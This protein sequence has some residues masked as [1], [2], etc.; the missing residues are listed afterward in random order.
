MHD[1]RAFRR[2]VVAGPLHRTELFQPGIGDGGKSRRQRRDLVHDLGG[3]G[4]A[5]LKAHRLGKPDGDFPVGKSITRRHH[6][7]DALDAPLGIGEGAVLLQEGRSRQEDVGIVGGLVEEEVMHDH[8]F[9]RRQRRHHMLGVGVGLQ[10]VFALHVEAHERAFDRS[11]EHVG[12]AQARFR[13]ELDVPHRLELVAH[14]VAR[15]MPVAGE[16]MRERAHVAGALHVVLAAQRVHADA[17]TADIAGRHREVG[18]RNHC[19]RPLA[20]LGHAKA[21]IDRAITAGGEQPRGFAQHLRIDAGHDRGRFR[22]V[23]RQRHEGGPLLELAPVA[24]LAHEGFIDEAFGNDDVRQ[25]REHGNVGAGHQR[26]MQR[27]EVRG[28]HHLR[29]A[30]INHDELGALAQ[31][32]LQPRGEYGVGGGGIGADHHDDVGMLDGIEILRAGRGTERRRQA[33]AGRRMADAGAGVDIVVAESAADQLLHQIGFFIGAAG[34]GDAA[35]RIAAILLLYALEFRRGEAECLVP[36]DLAPGILDPLADHRFED[37]LLVCGI[38]PGEA[39]LDAGMAAIGLAVL[40]GHHAHDFLAAHFRLEGA[41]DAA[42]STRRHHGMFRLADLDHG[43]F[44]QRRGRAGLYAGAAGHAFGAEKILVHAGRNAA[45][46]TAAGNRQRK[47][48]LHLLAG[49]DAARAD[50]AL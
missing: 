29:T 47:C 31:P 9:H 3:V 2:L 37:A 11:V 45:V 41:A 21:V 48:S 33:V 39:P 24:A 30:R 1:R 23:L 49:A 26:Q 12:N 17:G 44:R 36:R 16:F 46:K 18:D 8:A 35:D 19:G 13:I 27:L 38:A 15:D 50:D 20:V 32:L 5:H 7:A 34:G 10:D 40:V 42:V 6:L 4:V 28:F 25:R 43:F 22:A 14:G